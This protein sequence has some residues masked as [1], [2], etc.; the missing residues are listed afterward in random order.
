MGRRTRSCYL[1]GS[2]YD[3]CPT[4]SQ[5]KMKPSWMAEFHSE[6]CKNIFDIATRFNM[7]LLTKEEAK[8]AMEQ[9]D[10][11]N[12]ENFNSY[13][14]RDL[15]NIFAEEPKKR[16]KRAEAL[17]IDEEVEPVIEELHEVVITENE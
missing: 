15:E 2:K 3:Y 12:K 13:V 6:N 9:C 1:C 10:L 11:T 14:Q 17:I 4:C 8:A 5:D 16:G 7:Q